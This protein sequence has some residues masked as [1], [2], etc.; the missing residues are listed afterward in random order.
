MAAASAKDDT[1]KPKLS[2]KDNPKVGDSCKG[3][4]AIDGRM[5]CD[6][7]IKM[8]CSSVSKYKWPKLGECKGG[9]KCV[10]GVGGKSASCKYADS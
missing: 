6:G 7:N 5:A 3:L 8:F 1:S 2:A 4:S 10:V 9:T